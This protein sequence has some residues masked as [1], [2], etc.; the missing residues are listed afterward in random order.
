MLSIKRLA[1]VEERRMRKIM[2]QDLKRY[3]I[4]LVDFGLN[5]IDSEQGG[6]RPAVIIQN[7]VGNFYSSTTIVMPLTSQVKN[8]NQPTHTLIEKGNEKG[9]VEDSMVL[10]EC[11]RQISEKRIIKYLGYISDVKEKKEI[12][13]VYDANFGEVA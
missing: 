11:M 9:L 7:D 3:D 4:V 13:R 5:V 8:L 10:G 2:T 6:I 1:S 12:R